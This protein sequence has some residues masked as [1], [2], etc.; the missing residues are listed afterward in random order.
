MRNSVMFVSAT[1]PN[2]INFEI[3]LIQPQNNW[4]PKLLYRKH[5]A[6]IDKY[7]I[8]AFG[9]RQTDWEMLHCFK[10]W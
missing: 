1:L 4:W 3:H 2:I 9:S 6:A 10:E 7:E 5:E 8:F